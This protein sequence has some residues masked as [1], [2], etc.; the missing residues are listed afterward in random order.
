M[1]N[2]T[3]LYHVLLGVILLSCNSQNTSPSIRFDAINEIKEAEKAFAALALEKGIGN[4][5]LEFA[6]DSAVLMRSNK[7]FKGRLA[8][9]GVFSNLEKDPNI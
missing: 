1:K 7:V 4:A 6:A 2:R 3:T 9:K 5:F 8:I